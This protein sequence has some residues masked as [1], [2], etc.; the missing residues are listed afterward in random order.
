MYTFENK[1]NILSTNNFAVNFPTSVKL[2]QIPDLTTNSPIY[3]LLL[4]IIAVFHRQSNNFY[5]KNPF[6]IFYEVFFTFTC[7]IR[8]LQYFFVDSCG[9]NTD[10]AKIQKNRAVCLPTLLTSIC[11]V[12][13]SP[14]PRAIDF[15][16][17][18]GA[19]VNELI[20]KNFL[21]EILSVSVLG[22]HLK[23]Q[24]VS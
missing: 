15:I 16:F 24:N 8:K 13:F 23:Y 20:N 4:S 12:L 21:L 9:Y 19:R 3:T 11:V 6:Q 2:P 22:R 18:K 1:E 17:Q 14:T 10:S 7:K 5:N